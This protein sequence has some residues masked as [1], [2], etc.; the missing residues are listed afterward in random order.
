MSLASQDLLSDIELQLKSDFLLGDHSCHG[1]SHW[2]RVEAFGLFIAERTGAEIH[3]VRLFALF[4]DCRRLTDSHDP[5]HGLRGAER[6]RELRDRLPLNDESF[7][8]LFQAC[9]DHTDV[10]YSSDPTIGA[11]W[12]ADRLDLGRVGIQTDPKRLN[13]EPAQ[14]L[15]SYD[16]QARCKIVAP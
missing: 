15:A 3:V 14:L 10:L 5:D 16:W 9:A 6:A 8:L 13:T 2:K 12:D 1:P 7:Q 4:H 11:C